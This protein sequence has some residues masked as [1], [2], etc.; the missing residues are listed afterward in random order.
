MASLNVTPIQASKH[1]KQE[2]RRGGSLFCKIFIL[3][4]TIMSNFR[5]KQDVDQSANF[6]KFS[7][8]FPQTTPTVITDSPLFSSTYLITE[9]FRASKGGHHCLIYNKLIQ[10]IYLNWNSFRC[11]PH[12]RARDPIPNGGASRTRAAV[13]L[14]TSLFSS[15]HSFHH[16]QRP[17][18]PPNRHLKIIN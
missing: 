3:L 10:H 13:P 8:I 1:I 7:N 14:K 17:T 12:W 4:I 11:C 2:K 16:Y 6:D 5:C 18:Q 15:F 9:S